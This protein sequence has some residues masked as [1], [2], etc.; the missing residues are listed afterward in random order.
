MRLNADREWPRAATLLLSLL[1]IVVAQV[2]FLPDVAAQG[3]TDRLTHQP[4]SSGSYPYSPPGTWLPGRDCP[5]R[6]SRVSGQRT[7]KTLLRVSSGS[8]PGSIRQAVWCRAQC[9]SGAALP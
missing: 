6:A 2:I 8:S 1:V 4:P 7:S 5:M 9:T 3:L